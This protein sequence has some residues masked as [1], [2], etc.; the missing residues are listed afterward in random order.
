MGVDLAVPLG[1]ASSTPSHAVQAGSRA[2]SSA[3]GGKPPRARS[4][5]PREQAVRFGPSRVDDRV[6]VAQQ[7]CGAF[8]RRR[9]VRNRALGDTEA[10]DKGSAGLE[11]GPIGQRSDV[12]D[13][14]LLEPARAKVHVERSLLGGDLPARGLGAG[15]RDGS[16]R[17][18]QHQAA[19]SPV[20]ELAGTEPALKDDVERSRRV[21]EGRH[22]RPEHQL[23][24]P[25]LGPFQHDRELGLAES[26][27]GRS[28]RA[29]A[30][31]G[32]FSAKMRSSRIV[33]PCS[34]VG[35]PK[36]K[37]RSLTRGATPSQNAQPIR[38]SL[39]SSVQPAMPSSLNVVVLP[40][41]PEVVE[42]PR[43]AVDGLPR[44]A[45]LALGE[46]GAPAGAE[47]LPSGQIPPDLGRPAQ[48]AAGEQGDRDDRDGHEDD[49]GEDQSP[50]R[51]TVPGPGGHG[52]SLSALGRQRAQRSRAVM[53]FGACRGSPCQRPERTARD[54]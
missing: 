43:V 38:N 8:A 35:L 24:L 3:P 9:L 46:V 37:K 19:R 49:E 17:A 2:G 14:T 5:R 31:V 50:R 30:C 48:R 45:P 23:A 1:H 15:D 29:Y 44:R 40:D 10:H 42:A 41:R 16:V 28:S 4:T 51:A 26:G 11:R 25:G 39:L 13:L 6:G 18:S 27:I 22:R 21:V 7:L 54:Q 34:P 33:S 53:R 36:P 32:L 12:A 47:L 52:T 20:D